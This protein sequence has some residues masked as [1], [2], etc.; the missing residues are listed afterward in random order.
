M[1][2]MLA[3]L[4][5]SLDR[6]PTL[7]PSPKGLRRET[8]HK[9]SFNLPALEAISG[10]SSPFTR[11]TE[12]LKSVQEMTW[13]DDLK[14][15]VQKKLLL[16]SD[17]GE[18][19]ITL[20][21]NKIMNKMI[22]DTR[23]RGTTIVIDEET[24]DETCTALFG[25]HAPV[26]TPYNFRVELSADG[27]QFHLLVIPKAVVTENHRV[28]CE[29]RL[30][31]K[32]TYKQVFALHKLSITTS[33]EK[34]KKRTCYTPSVLHRTAKVVDNM[35]DEAKGYRLQN[36]KILQG[37]QVHQILFDELSQTNKKINVLE[38]PKLLT[39]YY[40]PKSPVISD[41]P[42]PTYPLEFVQDW[43]S[44]DLKQ[45]TRKNH[46]PLDFNHLHTIE[47][48]GKAHPIDSTPRFQQYQLHLLDF[49]NIFIDVAAFLAEMHERGYVHLDVKPSNI[50]IK[51]SESADKNSAFKEPFSSKEV[52]GFLSDFDLAQR[53]GI[54][55]EKS[56]HYP[57]WD[58][59]SRKFNLTS[60]FCDCNG[61]AVSILT[62]LIPT[63][64]FHDYG[65]VGTK[66]DVLK[67]HMEF[68]DH[69]YVY[70][71]LKLYPELR[72]L[73]FPRSKDPT[74]DDFYSK[75]LIDFIDSNPNPALSKPTLE[76]LADVKK[77][78]E[79]RRALASL[80]LLIID[81]DLQREEMV[82]LHQT[83]PVITAKE[84]H[85]K[86]LEFRTAYL[87]LEAHESAPSNPIPAPPPEPVARH[88]KTCCVVQ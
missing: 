86:L 70:D 41:L 51:V 71:K 63:P 88:E 36:E 78:M 13:P 74:T 34:G 11:S 12:N 10:N 80:A 45:A 17:D 42:I 59:F 35:V 4:S 14:D 6:L 28:K 79:L 73:N 87:G 76:I 3:V 47:L 38:V 9:T 37:R 44:G 21:F 55:V 69:K 22:S 83:I 65:V 29:N 56:H 54:H 19:E 49:L 43:F 40:T 75:R 8:F 84:I 67:D 72:G 68:Y 48:R 77:E 66:Y 20:L 39:R 7:Y 26:P 60:P 1:S 57:Y 58:A 5:S 52:S 53:E 27:S 24:I 33:P 16:D 32:G 23:F 85:T 82:D 31:G 2:S 81:Q 46:L 50:L 61:F 18:D 30:L 64:A 25:E 15:F 62:F